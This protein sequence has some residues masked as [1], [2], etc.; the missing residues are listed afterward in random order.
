[1]TPASP[2]CRSRSASPRLGRP[3]VQR[4]ISAR[5]CPRR[6]PATAS[7]RRCPCRTASVLALA[8]A[9]GS[10]AAVAECG[11]ADGG[12][13]GWRESA[14]H[15]VAVFKAEHQDSG[16]GELEADAAEAVLD[17]IGAQGFI[18]ECDGYE[19]GF[20]SRVVGQLLVLIDLAISTM[21]HVSGHRVS[22]R[23]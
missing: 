4:S 22:L 7:C 14:H 9:G 6:I 13:G 2:G 20:E 15:V 23:R 5:G 21:H 1:M 8:A 16:F 18:E 3:G 17:V 11:A 12:P 10:S 19:V